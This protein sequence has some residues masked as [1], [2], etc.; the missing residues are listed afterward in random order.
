MRR[1]LQLAGSAAAVVFLAQGCATEYVEETDDAYSA[2]RAACRFK[3]GA[4]SEVT[5]G[6]GAKIPAG[7][8]EKIVVLMQ[9]NRSFD[10]LFHNLNNYAKR[11]DIDLAKE[12][13][14]P[15]K[16]DYSGEGR[17]QGPFVEGQHAPHLC[18]G[19]TNHEWYAAHEQFN[20]GKMN[21]FWQT[22]QSKTELGLAPEHTLGA[23]AL[24]WYD[25]RDIPFYYDLAATF[26]IGDKY[27]SSVLGPTFPNRD[28]L[29]GATSKGLTYNFSPTPKHAKDLGD[30]PFQHMY[31]PDNPETIF[32]A[33]EAK[34][35]S[36]KVY[37]AVSKFG[38]DLPI[39]AGVSSA[40]GS[41]GPFTRWG[42]KS[43]THFKDIGDYYEDAKKGE[44]P[45]VSFVDANLT[46]GA[47]PSNDDHPPG[48]IQ[49]GEKFV[50][51]IVNTLM[52]GKDW[53]RSAL[54]ITWDENGGLYDHVTPPKAC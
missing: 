46:G 4:K 39:V 23:R 33:L 9:E 20:N 54:F 31:D 5:A 13:V 28:F 12:I 35:I 52:T 41:A 51:T 43:I 48:N 45:A 3:R 37:S 40:I 14:Q 47:P 38:I 21:G 25:E 17:D 2:D 1:Y 8:V 10:H 27:F 22:N 53:K 7:T 49:D 11:S 32:D 16:P 34:G 50:A 30:H 29:Y 24:W 36:W 19:D 44:L 42:V 18:F 15:M 6:V 26:G